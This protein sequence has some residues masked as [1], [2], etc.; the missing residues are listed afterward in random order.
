[1]KPVERRRQSNDILWI[2]ASMIS[3]LLAIKSARHDSIR[4]VALCPLPE[5]VVPPARKFT[6]PAPDPL[7]NDTFVQSC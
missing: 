7:L 5:R 2:S 6:S 3:A 4:D 1:M